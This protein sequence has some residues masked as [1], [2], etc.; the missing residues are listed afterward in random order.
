[1]P[2]PTRLYRLTQ[3]RERTG[4]TLSEMAQLCDVT[5]KQGRKT[6]SDWEAGRAVPRAS[7]RIAFM[8]YLWWDLELHQTPAIFDE[9]WAMLVEEWEWDPLR[10]SEREQLLVEPPPPVL[11]SDNDSEPATPDAEPPAL[12]EAAP[13]APALTP[14]EPPVPDPTPALEPP[15]PPTVAAEAPPLVE[16]VPG[17][18]ERRRWALLVV[19]FLL[20][21]V[22]WRFW[23]G[24]PVVAPPP[25]SL[26]PTAVSTLAATAVTA[27]FPLTLTTPLTTIAAHM[28]S[29]VTSTDLS[30]LTT[31]LVTTAAVAQTGMPALLPNVPLSLTLI[32]G[33]F[34]LPD[35]FAGWQLHEECDY[36]VVTETTM[37]QTGESYLTIANRRPRCYSFYQDLFAPLPVGAAYRGAIWLRSPTG[38][39]RRGRLTL[40]ALGA[41]RAYSNTPFA[42]TNLAWRC[43]ETTLTIRQ[44]GHD[45]LRFEVYLDSHD[46]LEYHF[47]SASVS[48]G[49]K[50]L[51][52]APQ[53]TLTDL[54]IVQ[55]SGLVY[56]AA[57]VGVQA[58]VKNSGATDLPAGATLRYWVAEQEM[59]GPLAP[60]ATIRLPIPP[61][62]A[63]ETTNIPHHDFYLPI[64]LPP[65]KRYFIV[66]AVAM[67]DTLDDL[68]TALDRTARSFDLSPCSPD[69]LYCDVP[70]D[71]W[72]A[73]EIQAWFDAGISQGCRS[74]TDPFDNRPFCP[75]ALVQRWMMAIFLFR[76][77]EGK[78]YQPTNAYQGLFEDLPED[79]DSHQS[80]LRI[81]ALTTQRVDLRSDACPPRGE[82][83][84]FCPRDPL[85]R[86][87]FVRALL[88]LQRWDVS[89][90][91]GT[92]FT[93]L[94]AGSVEAQA[95]EYMALQGYLPEDDT[96]CPDSASYRRFCPNAPL[97]RAS[98]AVM[99]SRALGLVEP[100][101]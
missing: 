83:A 87:D 85:R 49:D 3:L 20:L 89:Q 101:K 84:R 73:A 55:P 60:D 5:S 18:R 1:M 50:S 79:F 96:D 21:W 38:N 23:P 45:Q 63:G 15:A 35:R 67:T 51:C 61:L 14:P 33:G 8:R 26:T 98:A 54:K 39:A 82:H 37:A 17:F 2:N 28:S 95:A 59:A 29:P 64:N 66:A 4:L 72:A 53:L 48:Q 97:R 24:T 6:V 44:P 80:A 10:T 42:V 88:A 36:R 57:T 70:A 81:E 52:P 56:P 91:A 16:S 47:D 46:G 78:D 94:E 9:V 41:N 100:G 93:D 43:L 92:R 32:N 76:R 71:H 90:I 25:I 22:G 19:P 74:N 68:T 34:D 99:M 31:T 69:T 77:L 27:S 7:R 13:P 65:G 62:A 30:L 12:I 86:I 75:D 58:A 40:W 11:A